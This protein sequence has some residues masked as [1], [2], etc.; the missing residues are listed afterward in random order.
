MPTNIQ[1][2]FIS[3][4]KRHVAAIMQT[5]HMLENLDAECVL[6]NPPSWDELQSALF[7]NAVDRFCP[8]M[9]LGLDE[10]QCTCECSKCRKQ[11]VPVFVLN[12]L[13]SFNHILNTPNDT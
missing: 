3:A 4:I 6:S 5:I 10:W 1:Q 11:P 7:P 2:T 9:F 8:R 13:T 12:R